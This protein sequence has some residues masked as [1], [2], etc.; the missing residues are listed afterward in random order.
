MG[1]LPNSITSSGHTWISGAAGKPTHSQ[2]HAE[3]LPH[4]PRDDV[5]GGCTCRQ[6][7]KLGMRTRRAAMAASPWAPVPPQPEA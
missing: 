7:L 6:P 4:R 3:V 1:T 5:G 2:N